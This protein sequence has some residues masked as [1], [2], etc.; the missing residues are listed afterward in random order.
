MTDKNTEF[1]LKVKLA[2]H[3]L[4]DND[5]LYEKGNKILPSGI[6]ELLGE[7]FTADQV[8]IYL[9]NADHLLIDTYIRYNKIG[10]LAITPNYAY[11]SKILAKHKM[12][13]DYYY[14]GDCL[15][16]INIRVGD[17]LLSVNEKVEGEATEQVLF[18]SEPID[19]DMNR[20]LINRIL[21]KAERYL[22]NYEIVQKNYPITYSIDIYNSR[23]NYYNQFDITK[24]EYMVFRDL[25]ELK[26]KLSKERRNK[27][28]EDYIFNFIKL[29]SEKK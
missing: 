28:D 17:F 9:N 21:T 1:E 11:D 2:I 10:D 7:N 4:L 3:N 15:T 14:G 29:L 22:Y 13:F 5:S 8:K 16:N 23:I 24:D 25:Y 12:L 19:S 26:K 18:K 27:S 6:K 20:S